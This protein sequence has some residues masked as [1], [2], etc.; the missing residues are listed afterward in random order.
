MVARRRRRFL[1]RRAQRGEEENRRSVL[2]GPKPYGTSFA[3]TK[4]SGRDFCDTGEVDR[5][6]VR[7][8]GVG[9]VAKRR[10]KTLRQRALTKR[11][12]CAESL[13]S[14][15]RRRIDLVVH[16]TRPIRRP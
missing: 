3:N 10:A 5:V 8:D 4:A 13:S 9:F 6:H 2:I 7:V 14:T 16:R 1:A 12:R 11:H 15:S